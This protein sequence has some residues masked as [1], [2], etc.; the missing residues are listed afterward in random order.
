MLIYVKLVRF[1]FSLPQHGCIIQYMYYYFDKYFSFG[2]SNIVDLSISR[3][4]SI[5]KDLF[6]TDYFESSFNN[7]ISFSL[8]ELLHL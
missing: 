2:W 7:L 8:Y 5:K 6:L 1:D 3:F 4:S